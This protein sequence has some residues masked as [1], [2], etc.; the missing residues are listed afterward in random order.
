M[1]MYKYFISYGGL[2]GG[3]GKGIAVDNTLVILKDQQPKKWYCAIVTPFQL[4]R[5]KT[6]LYIVSVY[7]GLMRGLNDLS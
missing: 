7:L 3:Q 5:V 2:E 1:R 6:K 4:V